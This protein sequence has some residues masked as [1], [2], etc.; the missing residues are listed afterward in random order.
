MCLLLDQNIRVF[1]NEFL[2]TFNH[3]SIFFFDLRTQ[4]S[5]SICIFLI[6]FNKAF[7]FNIL[8]F[9]DEI[10]FESK[11]GFLKNAQE[12]PF[13]NALESLVLAFV[14]Q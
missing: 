6:S 9:R 14:F 8:N 13:I 1:L 2:G 11:A 10:V 4:V 3:L 12:S 7:Q 5:M